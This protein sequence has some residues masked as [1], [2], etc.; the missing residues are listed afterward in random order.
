MIRSPLDLEMHRSPASEDIRT[1]SRD[2]SASNASFH[3]QNWLGHRAPVHG[4]TS[5][6][7]GVQKPR[8]GHS[9]FRG[10]LFSEPD[11]VS[12]LN[13]NQEAYSVGK[14]TRAAKRAAKRAGTRSRPKSAKE[15]GHRE[16]KKAARATSLKPQKELKIYTHGPKDINPSN[17]NHFFAS[18]LAQR[19]SPR[20]EVHGMKKDEKISTT[21]AKKKKKKR[22]PWGHTPF[23]GKLFS[24]P[25]HQNE[26]SLHESQYRT[27][28]EE[29][30]NL[31]ARG[32]SRYMAGTNTSKTNSRSV[33]SSVTSA[34]AMK[35]HQH[36]LAERTSPKHPAKK[37][38]PRW[39]HSVFRGKQFSNPD[40]SSKVSLLQG[41]SKSNDS[42]NN[43]TAGKIKTANTRSASKHA[44]A[45]AGSGH[46][47]APSEVMS[48]LVL[49]HN[50]LQDLTVWSNDAGV[51]FVS[52][53]LVRCL[54]CVHRLIPFFPHL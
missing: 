5:P 54:H 20:R 6:R 43:G 8:W 12:E 14:E 39:G 25:D 11:H 7:G 18:S 28:D 30:Q 51:F 41:H 16:G 33:A 45:L 21:T 50:H 19:T 32:F 44:G 46:A 17:A 26:M 40:H 49:Q 42:T 52:R 13:W 24:R 27:G 2:F 23:R 10:R 35:H 29:R 1:F 4:H 48:R 3:F 38:N 37:G 31:A 15:S 34:S 47:P 36:L 53:Q 9:P 22:K